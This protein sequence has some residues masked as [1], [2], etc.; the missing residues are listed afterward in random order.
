MENIS[1]GGVNFCVVGGLLVI[2]C[3]VKSG[4]ELWVEGLP[5]M[6]RAGCSSLVSRTGGLRRSARVGITAIYRS[7][8]AN[9]KIRRA[10]DSQ[11]GAA[12]VLIGIPLDRFNHRTGQ[13]ST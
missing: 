7:L 6:L 1:V 12:T 5:S 11:H 8:E 4:Q 13:N 3:S 9:W 10:K 2:F